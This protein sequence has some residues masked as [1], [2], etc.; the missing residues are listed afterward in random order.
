M[1]RLNGFLATL[2]SGAAGLLAGFLVPHQFVGARKAAG[3]K[4]NLI[5]S[6]LFAATLASMADGVIVT[7]AAGRIRFLNGAAERL[8]GCAAAACG[9][10]SLNSIFHAVNE[11]TREPVGNL[12]GTA[13]QSDGLPNR[14]NHIVLVAR[15][16]R[17][18]PIDQSVAPIRSP[19]GLPVGA[20][21]VFRDF[22]EQKKAENAL[23][24]SEERFR[25]MYE[26]A[27][28]GVEQASLDGQLL[29]ANNALC[30]ML[31]YC[32]EEEL[33]KLSP[34]HLTHPLDLPTEQQLL[35]QLLAGQI[36]HACWEK[37]CL[38]K[39]GSP[40]W[41]R[42]NS[43]VAKI[44]SPYRFS[45][46]EDISDWKRTEAAL[47]EAQAKLE[48]RVADL[49]KN[50]NE[51]TGKLDEMASELRHISYSL[52]HDMRA[53]LRGMSGFAQTV[54]E[55][56]IMGHITNEAEDY[57][58][59]I[60]KSSQRLDKLVT[61][62]LSYINAVLFELPMQPVELSPLLHGII[63]MYPNLRPELADIHVEPELPTV[64]GNESLLTQCFANLLDNAVKFV[65]AG[66]R[67]VIHVYTQCGSGVCRVFVQDNGIGISAQAKPRLFGMFQKL[68]SKYEGTG[69]GLAIV[70]KVVER[71]GGKVGVESEP[72]RG[73]CFWVELPT[74]ETGRV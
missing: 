62:A 56:C 11:L 36:P 5:E 43:T 61:D 13:M 50:V 12:V 63:E 41:V 57:C 69:I 34:T 17:E 66:V 23:R 27:P 22:T 2:L 26:Y 18:T 8:T 4:K 35:N 33:R 70:R 55:D 39:D 67:P 19:K 6:E 60:I 49:E 10:K 73:S 14:C 38:R 44:R 24:D 72:C 37:R 40:L 71:M 47:Q 15:D 68:D 30:R 52:I 53:P 20:V 16:G 28:L 65:E 46:I 64:M 25:A 7:D 21:L 54:L 48:V 42:M 74:V 45:M 31:G 29:A 58:R 1:R 51:R 32:E 59:R 3:A 9:G